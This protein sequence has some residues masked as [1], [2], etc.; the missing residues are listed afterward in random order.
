MG[1]KAVIAALQGI[2]K[3]INEQ[4]ASLQTED[5]VTGGIPATPPSAPVGSVLMPVT[6]HILPIAIDNQ[7]SF[8]GYMIDNAVAAGG[9]LGSRSPYNASAA[10]NQHQA[11]YGL[12]PQQIAADRSRWPEVLDRYY[13]W[14]AYATPEERAARA[15]EQKMSDDAWAAHWAAKPAPAAPAAGDDDVVIQH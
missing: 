10:F 13:N 9:D 8:W 12:T 6:G 2:A 3:S 14:N 1:N 7:F 4:I 5:I 15:A 11:K